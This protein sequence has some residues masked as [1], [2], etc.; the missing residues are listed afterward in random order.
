MRFCLGL[1]KCETKKCVSNFQFQRWTINDIK[2]TVKKNW[3]YKY[4]KFCLGQTKWETKM[5]IEI[6]SMALRWIR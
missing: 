5:K 1:D 6:K 4:Q 3:Q 2:D